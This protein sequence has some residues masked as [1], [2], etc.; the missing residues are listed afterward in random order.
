MNDDQLNGL[1]RAAR[2][3]KHDTSH[4]EYGFE[5]RLL[6]RLRTEREEFVPWYG[7]AWR[8]VPALAAIVVAAGLW[9]IAAPNR[10]RTDTRSAIADDEGERTLVTF[11]TGE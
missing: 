2:A 7:F 5:A 6:S 8:L 1:F 9:V 10:S 3:V 11:F 4:A